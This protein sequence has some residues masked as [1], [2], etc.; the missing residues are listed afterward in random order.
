MGATRSTMVRREKPGE[1]L[2]SP[3]IALWADA[4]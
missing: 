2:D 4:C 3:R 1:V